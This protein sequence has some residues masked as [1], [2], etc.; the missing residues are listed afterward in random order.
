MKGCE[1]REKY[2]A[3]LTPAQQ[4]ENE[5]M[6]LKGDKKQHLQDTIKFFY[7]NFSENWNQN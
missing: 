2:R 4:R 7:R 6:A 3:I 1:K 5:N